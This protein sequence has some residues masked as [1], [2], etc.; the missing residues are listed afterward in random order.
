MKKI[1][2]I[3]HQVVTTIKELCEYMEETEDVKLYKK[4]LETRKHLKIAK[5]HLISASIL[6]GLSDARYR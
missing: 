3:R 5:E 2:N 4:L 1:E 6:K